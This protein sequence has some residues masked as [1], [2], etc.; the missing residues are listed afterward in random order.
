MRSSAARIPACTASYPAPD[1]TLSC[2]PVI[3]VHAPSVP[4]AIGNHGEPR[5]T[6]L[7]ISLTVRQKTSLLTVGYGPD[8]CTAVLHR[9]WSHGCQRAQSM[10]TQY[11]AASPTILSQTQFLGSRRPVHAAEAAKTH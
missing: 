2:T 4:V 7:R 5:T 9:G 10:R 8:L 3:L 11:L 6:T 1:R